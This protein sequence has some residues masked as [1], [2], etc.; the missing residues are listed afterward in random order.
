MLGNWKVE[1][2][3]KGRRIR[4]CGGWNEGRLLGELKEDGRNS[5]GRVLY[6]KAFLPNVVSLTKIGNFQGYLLK[7]EI[8]WPRYITI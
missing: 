1:A 7:L 6:S 8:V 4:V 2:V 5:E 3:R